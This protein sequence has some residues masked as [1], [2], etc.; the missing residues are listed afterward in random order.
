ML[1]YGETKRSPKPDPCAWGTQRSRS[2]SVSTA[3]ALGPLG[4][5]VAKGRW[6]QGGAA[7]GLWGQGIWVLVLSPDH[8]C[9]PSP[10][11][12]SVSSPLKWGNTMYHWGLL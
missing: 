7:L 11:Q 3:G 12:A 2:L 8:G 10:F 6:R 9:V 1:P 4:A 5:A